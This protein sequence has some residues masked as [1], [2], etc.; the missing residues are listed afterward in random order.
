VGKGGG[1]S[2]HSSI[3]IGSYISEMLKDGE[4]LDRAVFSYTFFSQVHF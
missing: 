4:P 2:K 1:G 3:G